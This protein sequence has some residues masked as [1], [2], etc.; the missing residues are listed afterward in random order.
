MK[1]V[2][3]S[4]A[5][6]AFAAFVMLAGCNQIL[7]NEEGTPRVEVPDA[8]SDAPASSSGGDAS[9]EPA[10][11]AGSRLCFGVCKGND[12]PN[13]GCS[14]VDCV[15]CDLPNVAKDSCKVFGASG[16]QCGFESC[17]DGF[18]D[19][20]KK[21]EDGC[22]I[23]K[24]D[25]NNCGSCDTKCDGG[26]L[27][28]PNGGGTFACVAQCPTE[29][30][31]PCN[32]SCIDVTQDPKNCGGCNNA[33]ALKPGAT[34]TCAGSQ[35]KSAC[36]AATPKD[37]GTQCV[38]PDDPKYC[39]DGCKPCPALPGTVAGCQAGKCAY[40]CAPGRWDCNQ[41]LSDGC[42][43]TTSCNIVGLCN[44]VSC[45]SD[46]TCCNGGCQAKGALC[47]INL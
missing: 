32:G 5:S 46:Q 2:I 38:S 10:C 29:T 45:T 8:A 22:E 1:T 7:G 28:A 13:V 6:A 47:L 17:A 31:T 19:C 9:V 15:A 41:N 33:C 24:N 35:C 25:A 37:C 20:N 26:K 12:D 14:S 18:L 3:R 36:N 44:G 23:R 43:S 39:L 42:E 11:A 16:Y 21:P 27:C 4:G 40:A 34:V 30:P